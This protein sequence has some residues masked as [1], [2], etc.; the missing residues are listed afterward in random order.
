MSSYKYCALEHITEAFSSLHFYTA[1]LSHLHIIIP[2]H[3]YAL[4]TLWFSLSWSQMVCSLI[5]GVSLIGLIVHMLRHSTRC[6]LL[7]RDL[8]FLV[9][10]LLIILVSSGVPVYS[11]FLYNTS[12]L[13][14]R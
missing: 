6:R 12:A 5:A 7:A 10:L 4:V 8:V 9:F 3:F 13:H 1:I 2:A 14:K 11:R